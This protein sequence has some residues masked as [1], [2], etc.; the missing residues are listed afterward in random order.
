MKKKKIIIIIIL[1]V[2]IGGGYYLKEEF[3]KKKLIE[4][5]G[6]RIEKYLKYNY[7]NYESITFDTVVVNPTGIPH[8]KGYVNN[9]PELK[10]DVGIYDDHFNAGVNWIDDEKSLIPREE[11]QYESKTVTEIEK[12]ENRQ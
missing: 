6:P 9:N 11:Y 8:I 1:L 2:L 3:D 12:E 10:F 7:E 5:E 4:T